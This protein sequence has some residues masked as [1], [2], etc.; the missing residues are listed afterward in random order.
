M[1]IMAFFSAMTLGVYLGASDGKFIASMIFTFGLFAFLMAGISLV[2]ICLRRFN[3]NFMSETGEIILQ[4][5]FY[6]IASAILFYYG[7]WIL[8]LLALAMFVFGLIVIDW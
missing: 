6:M 8:G 4:C 3:E 5:I 7:M 2:N 1:Q